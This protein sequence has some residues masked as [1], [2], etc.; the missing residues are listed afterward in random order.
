MNSAA[1]NDGWRV[2]Q[3][4]E[5]A[6]VTVATLHFYE[7]QGLISSWRN[8]GNQRRYSGSVL[9]RVAVIKSAQKLGISLQ[10]IADA[11]SFLP[12][13]KAPTTGEWKAMSRRWRIALDEKINR[14]T[15]L[16]DQLDDC[17]GCGC[18]SIKACRLR[19]P[20]DKAAA[21]GSGAVFWDKAAKK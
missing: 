15:L 7:T 8:A 21:K 18:L 19:N 16:R 13:D 2:G 11:M 14:L 1:N 6:G 4:A 17:I 20:E 10:E 9:R 3:V 5:R 12:S